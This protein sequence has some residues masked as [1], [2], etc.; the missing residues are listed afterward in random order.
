MTADTKIDNGQKV[1]PIYDK[2]L[3]LTIDK[4]WY[5]LRSIYCTYF[6]LNYQQTDLQLPYFLHK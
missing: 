3:K 6:F 1:I 2:T 5:S 4:K